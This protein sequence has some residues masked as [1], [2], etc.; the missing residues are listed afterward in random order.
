MDAAVAELHTAL[1][2]A[3]E[4]ICR[5]LPSARFERHDGHA[6][7]SYPRIPLPTFNGV[8]TWRDDDSVVAA[9]EAALASVGS[10][11]VPLGVLA[12]GAPAGVLADAA[13]VGL[14]ETETIP[15]MLVRS[16][17]FNVVH[18]PDTIDVDSLS[19]ARDLV[20]DAFAIPVDW[21]RPMYTRT[22]LD[23]AGAV[24]YTLHADGAAVSTALALRCGDGVG[25]FNVATPAAKRGRGYGAAVTSR[26]V[27]DAFE[28]GATFAFLQ[29]SSV[30]EPVY[31]RLGFDH[32]ATYTLAYAPDH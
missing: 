13:R 30:G 11:G 27:V 31:R 4:A 25:I 7:L 15:G 28:D 21:F 19:A 32:V 14:S 16:A 6:V 5:A 20:A 26:A 23:D 17:D 8:W 10:A 12:L 29:S 22:V 24:V 3:F 1:L 9:L 18:T 2:D